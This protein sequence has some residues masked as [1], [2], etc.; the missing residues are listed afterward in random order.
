MLDDA[1]EDISAAGGQVG[2]TVIMGLGHN[3]LWEKDRANFDNWARKFD[4]EADALVATLERLGAT[5]IVWVTLREPSESVIPAEGEKQYRLYV[6]YFPY[7]NERLRLLVE[8][9]PEIVLADWAAVSNQEGLTYDAMHLTGSGIRLMID[10]I[11]TRRRHL[12]AGTTAGS[13]SSLKGRLRTVG[14]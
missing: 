5:K 10:T 4:R 3:T 6:W 14:P 7:V 8:R 12:T 11:R 13:D 1:D 9:H 2:E